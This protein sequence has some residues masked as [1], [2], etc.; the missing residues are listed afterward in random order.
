MGLDALPSNRA[1]QYNPERNSKIYMKE[2][3]TNRRIDAEELFWSD[4]TVDVSGWSAESMNYSTILQC[5]WVLIAMQVREPPS[6]PA[7]SQGALRTAEEA[8]SLSRARS[9]PRL[10]SRSISRS[11]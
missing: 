4:A 1:A 7:P 6:S 3:S 10:A 8:C 9:T 2:V 11:R 5:V